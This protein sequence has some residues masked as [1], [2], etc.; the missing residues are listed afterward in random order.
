MESLYYVFIAYAVGLS[1][2]GGMTLKIVWKRVQ[3]RTLLSSLY[4]ETQNDK[5]P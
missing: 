2:L 4:S 3:L 1:F 5:K